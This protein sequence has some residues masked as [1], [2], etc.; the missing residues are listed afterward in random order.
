VCLFVTCISWSQNFS[1][2]IDIM[3]M[4]L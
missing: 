4:Q 3:L 2:E 1:L